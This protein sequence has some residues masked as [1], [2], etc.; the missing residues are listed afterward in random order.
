MFKKKKIT[1]SIAKDETLPLF[2]RR[3]DPLLKIGRVSDVENI[4]DV[5]GQCKA[6]VVIIT[7]IGGARDH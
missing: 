6:D 2:R 7:P 5:H 3:A 4:V 1:I